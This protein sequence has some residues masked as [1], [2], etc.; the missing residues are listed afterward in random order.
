MSDF[1]K[2]QKPEQ[3]E[4]RPEVTEEEAEKWN[5]TPEVFEAFLVRDAQLAHFNVRRVLSGRRDGISLKELKGSTLHST[6]TVERTLANGI[7]DGSIK[8]V[9][10]EY[11]LVKS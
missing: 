4:V 9:K 10:G 11:S 7:Q 2:K 3:K 6:E 8:E 5:P 1:H